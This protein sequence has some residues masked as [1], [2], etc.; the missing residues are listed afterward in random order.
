MCYFDQ[1]VYKNLLETSQKPPGLGLGFKKKKT[2][3]DKQQMF[4]R[5]SYMN[6]IAERTSTMAA[7]KN[8]LY[9]FSEVNK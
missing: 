6:R 7:S 5:L 8:L 9:P 3:I 1:D 2:V 4:L